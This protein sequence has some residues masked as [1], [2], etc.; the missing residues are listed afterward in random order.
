[1]GLFSNLFG[2]GALLDASR[3]AQ[4]A[5]TGGLNTA[6]GTLQNQ[7]A[8]TAPT[9]QPWMTAGTGALGAESNLLGLG[10]GAAQQAAITGLQQSPY[11]QSLYN[12]GTQSVLQNAA[13]TGGLRGGNTNAS[14]YNLGQQTLAQTIQNQLQNLSG[15]STQGLSATGQLG[16]MGMANAGNIANLQN[17]IGQTNASAIMQRGQARNSVFSGIGNMLESAALDGLTGGMGGSLL[18][19]AGGGGL[20]SILG[21]S[22]GDIGMGGSGGILGLLQGGSLGNLFG[23]GSSMPSPD[24][25]S[26]PSFNL[27]ASAPSAYGGPSMAEGLA[28]MPF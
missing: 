19:G 21:S 5:A 14:L 12:Q 16:Q 22:M 27:N 7:Y 11:F 24:F 17:Q 20:G 15:L 10:G 13:A 4:A 18:G 8:A 23:L 25:G 6:I 3:S 26:F 1:M 9:Y 28:S 2:Q